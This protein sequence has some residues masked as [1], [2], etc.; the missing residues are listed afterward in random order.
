MKKGGGYGVPKLYVKFWWP[1][2]LALKF[3]FLFLKLAEIQIFIPQSACGG[4]VRRFRFRIIP[5]KTFFLVLP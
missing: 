2:F 3:T 1:L 5:K 4:G